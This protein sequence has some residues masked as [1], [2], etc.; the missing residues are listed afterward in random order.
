MKR[1]TFSNSRGMGAE[2]KDWCPPPP[3]P[4]VYSYPR[5]HFGNAG[6][7]RFAKLILIRT[8]VI[9]IFVDIIQLVYEIIYFGRIR[10]LRRPQSERKKI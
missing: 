2:N 3:P 4:R 5:G 1:T 9:D 10:R 6:I 7:L 8:L